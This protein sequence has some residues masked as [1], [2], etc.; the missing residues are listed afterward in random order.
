MNESPAGNTL[1]LG[2][3][4]ANL[5]RGVVASHASTYHLSWA[6]TRDVAEVVDRAGFEA[7]VPVARWK[8]LTPTTQFTGINYETLTWA[9]G[10]GPS[11]ESIQLFSTIHVPTIHPIVA[12]RQLTTIDHITNGRAGL[13][14]VVGWFPAEFEMFGSPFMSH[15]DRYVYAGEWIEC[16]RRLWTEPGEFDFDGTYFKIAKGWQEPKPLQR[17]MPKIMQ[18]GGSED[19][20]RFQAQYAD[21]AFIAATQDVFEKRSSANATAMRQ[22]IA[23]LRALAS[24]EFHRE[25]EVWNCGVVI[26]KDT[27]AEARA[28]FEYCFGE[29]GDHEFEATRNHPLPAD[30]SSE[31]RKEAEMRWLAGLGCHLLVGTAEQV[32]DQI[33]FLSALGVDGVALAWLD[34]NEGARQF[35]SEI[36]PLIEQAGLRKPR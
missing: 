31:Q 1:K 36:L 19:G 7:M 28:F 13:N 21:L 12:A 29:M 8:G 34:Y 30:L 14:V 6:G 24:S 5:D 4:G 27:E 35:E 15:D 2:V 3:F 32:S 22:S 16:V 17:P 25:L 23:E 20:R 10:L 11:T 33:R 9:A 18:A 26:C